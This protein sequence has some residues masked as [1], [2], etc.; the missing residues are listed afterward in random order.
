MGNNMETGGRLAP[1][2]RDQMKW[3]TD[4]RFGMFLHWGLYSILGRGEWVMFA[5]RMD[6][7]EYA[8][9]AERFDASQYD[10]KEWAAIAKRAGMKYM[11]LTARHHDGFSLWDSK[12][13]SFS[14][15]HSAA[16]RDLVAEYVEACRSAGLGVGLYYSPMD[17]RFPGYFFPDMYATS[18]AE[19]KAQCWAQIR[20]LMTNYGKIDILWY[21]GAWLA[22]GGIVYGGSSS[23]W[24]TKEPQDGDREAASFWDS[25]ALNKMVRQLQPEIIISPRSGWQGDFDIRER[26]IGD[27][28][29]DRPW[30]SCDCL[31]NSWGYMPGKP[32]S[33][34]RS[35]IHMLVKV[36]V[37]DG[38]L[39]LNVGP[40][41]AGSIEPRQADRLAQV[42][43]WLGKYGQSIYGTRGGPW[44]P[45]TWGGCTYSGNKV[46]VHILD[47]T[48]DEVT[49]PS[50]GCR[51]V[52]SGGLNVT[53][54]DVRQTAS[55]I[56]ISVPLER[57]DAIDTIIALELD[58]EP[59]GVTA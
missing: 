52:G 57:R 9:L 37:R 18:A 2:S 3:W 34:L 31:A 58:R 29:N 30:E 49:L 21:D 40:T 20:E 19:M 17:W 28:Q 42:G 26:K 44:A 38:N 41:A 56:R 11:V 16:R 1:L 22:H 59:S 14:S 51:V 10:P 45:A 48:D 24:H 12:A 6:K 39:L 33:S 5:E 55:D 4:A 50:M 32:V 43:D 54:V 47:W 27:A 8:R 15:A 13:S 46:Y 23:R 53:D 36:A 35:V 7:D 25:E